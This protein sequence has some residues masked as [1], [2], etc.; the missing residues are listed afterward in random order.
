MGVVLAARHETLG[1]DVAIKVLLDQ[2]GNRDDVRRFIR[3]ARATVRLRSE[4][5][6]RVLDV[7]TLEDGRPYIV[8]ERLEGSDLR[9]VLE[10][11]RV[12]G[13]ADAVGYVV[14][15]CEGLAEAH[16]AGVVHRDLKPGNLF[17]TKSVHGQPLVKVLDFGISKLDPRH[18]ENKLKLTT[19]GEVFG[20]PSYMS[21][22]QLKSAKDV[23]AR[24]DIWG[25]GV[26]LYE[27]LTGELP[28][29]A[30]TVYYLVLVISN[31]PPPAPRSLR[32]EIPE[33][34]ERVILRCLEKRPDSRFQSVV[35]LV[36][37]LEPFAPAV[38]AT[39]T[40]RVRALAG[41]SGPLTPRA[42]TAT[43]QTVAKAEPPAAAR[44]RK[45]W[46]VAAALVVG[47]AAA[48]LYARHDRAP[49]AARPT[50]VALSAAPSMPAS[51]P[52]AELPVA[53]SVPPPPPTPAPSREAAT[54]SPRPRPVP[55]LTGGV[56]T[57]SPVAPAASPSRDPSI[58]R[59]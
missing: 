41:K 30:D 37:A 11:S 5:V 35:E 49:A 15:A 22:E 26:I 45:A 29:Y 58:S 24:A 31:D 48:A 50:A 57:A 33:G 23:D 13:V 27:L 4:H 40:D 2:N 1:T 54:V 7:G 16:G 59:F 19:S 52:P 56:H 38:S 14:Q 25:L 51:A 53:V 47:G 17:L 46:L 28:F 6:A 10:E 44:G 9:D 3:E 55:R 20:S 32:A 42:T 39:A 12:L 36:E 21:P 34:L 18:S 8:M 43:E